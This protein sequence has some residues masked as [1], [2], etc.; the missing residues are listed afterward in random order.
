MI[1]SKF[2]IGLENQEIINEFLNSNLW[3]SAFYFIIIVFCA[4]IVEEFVFRFWIYSR[5]LKTRI[6]PV[7]AAIFSSLLFMGAHFNIQGAIAFFLIG[8]INCYLYERRGYWASV[9][10][11]FM[12]NFISVIVLIAAKVFQLPLT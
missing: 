10:N 12:F 7:M 5:L 4:P 11:H 3:K 6:S 1:L 2:N 9:A 8:L